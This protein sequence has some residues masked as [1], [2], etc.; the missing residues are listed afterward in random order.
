MGFTPVLLLSV[1]FMKLHFVLQLFNNTVT[2]TTPH[3]SVNLSMKQVGTVFCESH[4]LLIV[5]QL[6]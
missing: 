6:L 3:N 1:T 4:L 5:L 2:V